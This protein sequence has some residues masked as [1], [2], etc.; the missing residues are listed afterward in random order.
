MVEFTL[1]INRANNY[2]LAIDGTRVGTIS[3][4]GYQALSISPSSMNLS[5][6]RMLTLKIS[7][8]N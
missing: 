6:R 7:W 1:R 8:S 4:S 2:A 5:L 3:K